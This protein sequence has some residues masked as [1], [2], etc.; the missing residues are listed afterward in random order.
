MPN[1]VKA[2]T[3]VI[4]SALPQNE[5]RCDLCNIEFTSAVVALSHYKGK[6]HLSA[7]RNSHNVN[8]KPKGPHD[9]RG[10]FGIGMAFYK[11]EPGPSDKKE[12][13]GDKTP[14][15]MEDGGTQ[16]QKF[17]EPPE[18]IDRIHPPSQNIM[19]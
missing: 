9:P 19:T 16:W 14:E 13:Q 2:A 12:P 15:P 6:K 4:P 17:F 5:T 11:G 3:P 8:P 1:K 7:E 10:Q 18:L